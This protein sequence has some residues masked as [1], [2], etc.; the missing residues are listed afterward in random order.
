MITAILL[1]IAKQVT[2]VKLHHHHK[3]A[4]SITTLSIT[5]TLV[6]RD[7][8]EDAMPTLSTGEPTLSITHIPVLKNPYIYSSNLPS[9]LVFIVIGAIL[10][11]IL[12][13]IILYRITAHFK[14]NRQAMN[15]KETYYTN[16]TEILNQKGAPY[17][18]NSSILD[19]SN[20]NNNTTDLSSSSTSS[21]QGRS[22]RD[23]VLGNNKPM[24]TN[25]PSRNSMFI[26]PTM[27]LKTFELP[28]Y[29]KQHSTSLASLI[30]RYNNDSSTIVSTAFDEKSRITTT[31]TTV[32][33]NE[34]SIN[35]STINGSYL[36]NGKLAPPPPK[37]VVRAPS[38]YLEDLLNDKSKDDKEEEGV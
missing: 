6:A 17:S 23:S 13:L 15:E 22:Y 27:D 37:R 1:L 38:L 16:L 8:T 30:L 36:E 7:A 10:G 34:S 24:M 12:L 29:Q 19:L 32:D 11:A 2:G 14:Y 33:G 18:R 28:L 31:S 25:K 26:S 3:H 4:S 5:P 35:G 9:N 21:N 20:S